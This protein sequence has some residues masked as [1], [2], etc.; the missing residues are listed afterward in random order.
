MRIDLFGSPSTVRFIISVSCALILNAEDTFFGRIAIP[1]SS[2]MPMRNTGANA[3][4]SCGACLR[5]P[6]GMHGRTHYYSRG[7]ALA[8]SPYFITLG[9]IVSYLAQSSRL[10]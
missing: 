1:R 3:L 8:K 10:S 9:G 7:I 5:S 4:Q 6:Y 2:Y